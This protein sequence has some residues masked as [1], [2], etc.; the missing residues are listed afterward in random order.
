MVV[1]DN[2]KPKSS[3]YSEIVSTSSTF[4]VT[5][6]KLDIIPP[7]KMCQNAKCISSPQL[8]FPSPS[9]ISASSSK[10]YQ[11]VQELCQMQSPTIKKKSTN[12]TKI[13]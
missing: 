4:L 3:H 8:I 12:S 6:E 5:P 7:T 11:W 9:S 1:N 10:T 13:N 2:P